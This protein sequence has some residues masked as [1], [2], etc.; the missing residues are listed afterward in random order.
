[1][2]RC[3]GVCMSSGAWGIPKVENGKYGSILRRYLLDFKLFVLFGC[4]LL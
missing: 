2:A 4:E 3:R 1:M